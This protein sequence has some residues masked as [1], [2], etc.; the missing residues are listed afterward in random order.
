[1]GS[2]SMMKW[3]KQIT[4]SLVERLM[5]AEKDLERAIAIFD[6]ATAE[7]S[8]GFRHD[9]STFGLMLRRFISANKF[10][11]AGDMLNRMKQEKYDVTEDVF[12]SIYNYRAH[13]R[14]HKP[15]EVVLVSKKMNDYECEPTVKSYVTVFSILVDETLCKN[16]GTM[17]SAFKIFWEMP[18]CGHTPD[19]YTYGTLIN[20]LCRAGRTLEA[21]ELLIDM[22]T[23]GCLIHGFCQS[24]KLTDAMELFK[25]MKSKGVDPNGYSFQALELLKRMVR[26]RLVP[27]F[28]TYSFLIHGLCKE[29]KLSEAID[30][31]QEA[32]NFLDEMVLSGITPNR[33]TWGLHVRIHNRV[34]QGLCGTGNHSQACPLY[35]SMRSRGISVDIQ[36]FESR[37]HCFCKKGD[38]HEAARILDEMVIDGCIPHE[39]TWK[40]GMPCWLGCGTGGKC[41]KLLNC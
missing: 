5:S 40:Y 15:L 23:N 34:V 3:P 14:V 9:Q 36:T 41:V 24:N 11:F 26:K 21:K 25:E 19:S 4:P 27:N 2:K 33:V 37:I 16:N 7:Y 30:K 35:L 10:V 32:A 31:F 39:E 38:L 22:E 18:K 17:D 29:G 1:M 12:L 20:G 28:I 13:G 8:K 6:S